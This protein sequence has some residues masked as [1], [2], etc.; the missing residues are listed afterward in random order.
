MN[1]STKDQIIQLFTNN[2]E[3][4]F[5]MRG[6]GRILK[7]EPGVFQRAINALVKEGIL[8]SEY[9]A[10]ARFFR[11]ARENRPLPAK[12]ERS[13]FNTHLHALLDSSADR[14]CSRDTE[15]EL[16]A[17]NR[18]FADSIRHLFGVEPYIGLKTWELI[19][20]KQQEKLQGVRE[21]YQKVYTGET[22]ITEYEY[23]MPDGEIRALESSWAP[24]WDGGKVCAVG[25]VTR[26]VTYRKKGGKQ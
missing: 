24:I 10:N 17:W 19:P 16:L 20:L 9:K 8:E 12:K 14:I 13:Q 23:P 21:A 7:K 25:E 6:I 3:S 26:D 18:A 5:H 4:S 1:L 22:V 2:P 15:G 11:L